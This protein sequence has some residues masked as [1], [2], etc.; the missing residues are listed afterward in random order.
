TDVAIRGDALQTVEDLGV[1]VEVVPWRWPRNPGPRTRVTQLARLLMGAGPNIEVWKRR[2]QLAP[3]REA[4]GHEEEARPVDV[5]HIVLGDLA[6]VLA[7]ARA[8]SALLLFDIYSRQTD[9]ILQGS[10]PPRMIRYRLT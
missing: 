2:G 10:R 9:L 4:L 8:P 7:T 1:R 3:L 5:V 6:P